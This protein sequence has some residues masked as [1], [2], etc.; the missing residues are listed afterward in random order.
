MRKKISIGFVSLA[1]L[2]LFSGV[3]SVYELRRL[4]KQALEVIELNSR[5]TKLAKMMLNG[6]HRQNSAVLAAVFNDYDLPGD[7]YNLG[8][9]MFDE[10]FAEASNT[11]AGKSDISLV[12]DANNNYRKV[13][14]D[15]IDEIVDGQ[16][17]E[18]FL[19]TYLNAYYQL[20]Q[21][22]KN[23]LTSP[24]GSVPARAASLEADVYK[25]IT[26][27]ILTLAVAIIII[28]MFYF[29]VDSYYVRPLTK[30]HKS[31]ENNLSHN[32][33][34]EPHFESNNDE[35]N[36]LREMIGELTEKKKR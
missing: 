6:L 3:I 30:I 13:I 9:A 34:F 35:L 15:Y 32:I 25:T 18:Q 10:A 36:G 2:L 12:D 14:H 22:L 33:P 11:D 5:N 23:Y 31:L 27:S 24:E 7:E 4:S 20:D 17:N 29:F 16:N 26:P 19:E 1:L 8:R 28:L 21:T